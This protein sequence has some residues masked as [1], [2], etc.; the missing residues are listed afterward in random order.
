LDIPLGHVVLDGM[1]G[2]SSTLAPALR[3]EAGYRPAPNLA[4]F[5]FGQ[6][7]LALREWMAGAGVRI[8]F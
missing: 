2:V 6:T 7:D 5:G 3:L 4:L 8:S 1:L